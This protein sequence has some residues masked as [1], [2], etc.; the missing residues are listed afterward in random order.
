M[1]GSL[2][3]RSENSLSL[4]YACRKIAFY[5]PIGQK[6]E[7]WDL[8]NNKTAASSTTNKNI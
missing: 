7:E 1:K 6:E 3:D 2:C 5:I 4:S 8:K